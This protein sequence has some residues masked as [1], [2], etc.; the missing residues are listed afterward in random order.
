MLSF[1]P[2]NSHYDPIK[3]WNQTISL[4]RIHFMQ[5]IE[6]F[7]GKIGETNFSTAPSATQALR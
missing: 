7:Y 6:E 4:V 2:S 3:A 5:K 1:S